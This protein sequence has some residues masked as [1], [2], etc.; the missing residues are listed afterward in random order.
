LIPENA[1]K[2]IYVP[3]APVESS[4]GSILAEYW[5][6]IDGVSVADLTGN[7]NFPNRPGTTEFLTSFE[8]PVDRYDN[9][10]TRVR[11]W[12]RPTQSGAYTFW[13]SSDDASQLWLSTDQN[14]A[15][16][17]SIC[18]V[19][20]W[21]SS[22]EWGKYAEQQSKTIPLIAGRKYYIEALQ[23][24]GGGGDNLAVAWQCPSISRQVIPGQYLSPAGI[25]WVTP[26]FVDTTWRQGTG[27][28][29]YER[30]P[31]DAVNFK[32]L[33]GLD[34]GADIWGKGSGCYIRI[35]FTITAS[36]LA[37]LALKVRYDDGFVAYL[38]GAEVLRVNLDSQA[39]P[40]WDSVAQMS[41][42]DGQAVE[43]QLF[44]LTAFLGLLRE[45]QNVLALH[46]L[47]RSTTDDDMLLSVEM[48]GTSV[49][50][51]DISQTA[52]RYTGPISLT[53]GVRIKA[54]AF[55]GRWSALAEAEYSIKP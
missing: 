5:F 25:G 46:A 12:L 42:P 27:G 37:D 39:L 38:N 18:Q 53:Q 1:A 49:S 33:I 36:D 10:G 44:D 21:T 48:I 40:A 23:K 6:G 9:Y 51:G 50:Q 45:G 32:G 35:P 20:G 2:R 7:P 41:R 22:R 19:S 17:V 28:V 14:P 31:S 54:R 47:N 24:E 26:E 52:I 13:I 34:I 43:A 16:K 3:L 29:G 4:Q 30:N 11:G 8:I 15:N 55:D